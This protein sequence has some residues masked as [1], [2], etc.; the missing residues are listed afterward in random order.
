MVEPGIVLENCRSLPETSIV[1]LQSGQVHPEFRNRSEFP[2]EIERVT[3]MFQTE[4]G[5]K[6]YEV[7]VAVPQVLAPRQLATFQ[8]PFQASLAL[9]QHTNSYSFVVEGRAHA[10]E[11]K[12]EFSRCGY[13]LIRDVRSP[14]RHFFISHKD[15]ENTDLARRLAHYLR[16]IGFNG[17]V[18]EEEK[19]PGLDLWV[20][21]IIPA[22]DSCVGFIVLWTVEAEARPEN[23]HRELDRA[24]EMS[25]RLLLLIEDELAV[26]KAFPSA[27]EYVR[28][29]SKAA[30]QDLI[31]LVT[32]IEGIYR[33]GGFGA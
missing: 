33:T 28:V 12:K 27:V 14:S 16:K 1:Y 6:P 29:P 30:E 32:N 19:R 25:K 4:A 3:C 20:E 15:P 24:K 8:I 17:F 10:A 18:A 2:V 13:L 31:D 23:V 26:P 21:K 9:V 22:I 5:L 7:S 11:F